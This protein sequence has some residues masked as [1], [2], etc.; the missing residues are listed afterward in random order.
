MSTSILDTK[1]SVTAISASDD[2]QSKYL[3]FVIEGQIFG[4]PVM[5]V[6]QIVGQ[7]EV[8]SIPSFPYYAKGVIHLRGNMIPVIDVRILFQKTA[9]TYHDRICILIVNI[10]NKR[11][12]LIVDAMDE[13]INIEDVYIKDPYYFSSE[14]TNR[15]L[16]GIAQLKDKVVLILDMDR[17]LDTS[18]VEQLESI[19]TEERM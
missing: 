14:C 8:T 2:L 3:T 7:Q 19:S 4:L 17:I 1:S 11:I 10:Y 18:E 6:V 16:A 15:F 5:D 13:V 9:S 12:G